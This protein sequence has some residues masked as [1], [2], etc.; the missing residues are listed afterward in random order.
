M[1][2]GFAD[3]IDFWFGAPPAPTRGRARVEW[4]RKNDAFDA[5]IRARF[6][7]CHELAASRQLWSWES[8]PYAALALVIVL[9]QF[10]R[11]M[12]RGQPQAFDTDPLALAAA[13]RLV[14]RGFDRV[15]LP[16]ERGF[17]YLPFEHCEDLACQRRALALFGSLAAY[18]DCAGTIDYARR[19]YEIIARFGRFPHRNELLGRPSTP[20][21][22][23]FLRQPGSGF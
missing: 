11:N 15:Y 1:V 8:T 10:P 17:A 18:R 21:E 7:A 4:F 9:D 12:F 5:R 2:T 20:E 14:E 22:I 16:V 13:R 6:A 19:H 3:I 23:E